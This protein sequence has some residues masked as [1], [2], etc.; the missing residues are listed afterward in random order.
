MINMKLHEIHVFSL[1]FKWRKYAYDIIVLKTGGKLLMGFLM[2]WTS[3]KIEG[4][5][6]EGLEAPNKWDS[7]EARKFSIFPVVTVE[8]GLVGNTEENA[9]RMIS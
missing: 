9:R 8:S 7:K 2:S 5:A 4:P 6:L 3:S 1:L